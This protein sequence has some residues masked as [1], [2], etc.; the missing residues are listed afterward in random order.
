MISRQEP[1]FNK[2]VRLGEGYYDIFN[3]E[4][5]SGWLYIV[6]LPT[7]TFVEKHSADMFS[8]A[9]MFWKLFNDVESRITISEHLIRLAK[10]DDPSNWAVRFQRY[11]IGTKFLKAGFRP[12]AQERS[13]RKLCSNGEKAYDK[14]F[15]EVTD[16]V[17]GISRHFW[18]PSHYS[19]VQVM[20][21]WIKSFTSMLGAGRRLTKDTR[22]TMRP[23]A[24][25]TRDAAICWKDKKSKRFLVKNHN[26][27]YRKIDITTAVKEVGKNNKKLVQE[28]LDNRGLIS[29]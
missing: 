19:D 16:T 13:K 26:Y 22:E 21:Q 15:F 6:H 28:F 20:T 4:Y 10:G 1:K 11:P 27:F 9:R 5:R 17:L 14:T 25:L 29:G 23:F 7:K 24:A 18:L 8:Y 12:M 2:S 3:R